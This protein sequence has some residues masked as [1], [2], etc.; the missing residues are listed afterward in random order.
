MSS[1]RRRRRRSSG[2]SSGNGKRPP[3]PSNK[4]QNQRGKA[5][6]KAA[7]R[8]PQGSN[9]GFWGDPQRLPDPQ[10]DIRMTDDPAAVARSLGPPPLPGHEEI[11]QH[12]FRAVY[13]RGVMIAGALA[14]VGGLIPA[15]QLQ[16]HDHAG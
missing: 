5:R 13:D 11:A 10:T 16:D 15:E 3:A 7:T 12:Y 14:A 9:V 8:S 2:S 4:N 1:R 6:D